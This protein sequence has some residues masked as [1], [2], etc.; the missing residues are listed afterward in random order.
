[1]RE[2]AAALSRPTQPD[3]FAGGG[4]MGNRMRSYDWAATNLGPPDGWPQSLKTTISIMLNSRYAMWMA[5]GPDL[6]FFCND[7]YEPTLGVKS[8]W[9]LGA[10][11]DQV[12]A[13]IWGDVGP[14]IQHVLANGGA[15]WD[16]SLLLLLE[17]R[18]F[19]EE[20][21]HTFSYSPLRTDTGEIG[22]M[23]CVVTE[24][25]ERVIGSRR[26]AMLRDLAAGLSTAKSEADVADSVRRILGEESR[27]L[28]F[29]LTYLFEADSAAARLVCATGLPAGHPAA[30]PTIDAGA[31]WPWPVAALRSSASPVRV[32]DLAVLGSLPSGGW[33]EPPRQALVRPIAQQGE[34]AA[35]GFLV[36]AINPFRPI[37]ASYEGFIALLAGQIAGSLASAR[38]HSDARRRAEALAELDRAKTAF[39]SNISHE[40]RTPLTLILGPLEALLAQQT[41]PLDASQRAQIETVHRNS[42]RLLKLVNSLLDFSRIEAGRIDA[43]FR[44]TDLSLVTADLASSFRSAMEAA[45]LEFLVDAPSLPQPVHVDRDMW[46]KIV[47]NLLSNAFKFTMQGRVHVRLRPSADARQAVLTVSDTGAGIPQAE[48]PRVFERFHR[49]QGAAGRTFEGSGIGLALVQDLVKLHGGTIG[50]DSELGSGTTFTVALPLGTA[51][52]PPERLGESG[53]AE[54]DGRRAVAYAEEARRWLPQSAGTDLSGAFDELV[55][56]G[57]GEQAEP[58]IPGGRVVL[59]DDNAD[60]RDFVRRL[61]VNRGYDV[62]AVADGQAALDAIRANR[63]DLVL[64]DVMM[65]QL[66]GFGLL[67][68]IRG[69]ADLR[70]IP[71][72]LL[73]ARAGEEARVGGV[74]AGADDYLTKPFSASELMARVD[75]NVALARARREAIQTLQSLNETL[76]VRVAERTRERDRVW[77]LSRALMLA[78][79]PDGTALATNPAWAETLGW[80]EA[81]LGGRSLLDLVHPDDKA[82]ATEALESIANGCRTFQVDCR[83]RGRDGL[84]RYVEWNAVAEEGIIYAV[85]RDV[86]D[87]KAA[88]ERLRQSQKMETIGQLT[89]GVAH[90]FNNLLTVIIGNIET[91]RRHIEHMDDA[92]ASRLRRAS[93]QAM[94]GADR[95]ATLTQRLLAFSRRQPLDPKPI[96]ANRLILGMSDLFNRTLGEH[97]AVETVVGVRLWLAHADPNQLENALL[98]LAVNARDAMPKGGKLTIET[99]NV[100]LDE[101]YTSSVSELSPGQY[102]QIAVSD[103]GTGMSKELSAQAFEPFFTTKD[104]GHGTGL[105]L[106]QVYGFVKQSGGHVKI[107]SELG[108]GTTVKIYLPRLVGAEVPQ[109]PDEQRQEAPPGDLGEMV[110]VVEDDDDVRAYSVEALRD[111]GYRVCEA[112]NGATALRVLK[113]EPRIRLLFTDVGLPGGMNGRQLADAARAL[114][115]RLLVLFTT[116][117]AR[118]AIVHGGRLDPGVHL[119]TKPFSYDELAAKVRDVLDSRMVPPRILVVEDEPLVSMMAAEALDEAGFAVEEAASAAEA[120]AKLRRESEVFDAV[121]LDMRL[122]D[123]TGDNLARE[124]RAMRADLP[125]VIASGYDRAPLQQLFA[126]DARIVVVAKPYLGDDLRVALRQLGVQTEPA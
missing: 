71:V 118:N 120:L 47:L 65:P 53:A 73:S 117:Y 82:T 105:G 7:A 31:T 80:D 21:Y 17:R 72:L 84:Y 89:G 110:L 123:G 121:I 28:P 14:R 5:W 100:Y 20:T 18:G 90:D 40:F 99:C 87:A 79:T 104:V 57:R 44:P 114:S 37:D 103:T 106:S 69:D 113:N 94:R 67:S 93:D 26:L 48:I 102:V 77:R 61:L 86:T 15:T 107:Y 54:T 51:H 8:A 63:P 9:A 1:M 66:D 98:N 68:A 19:P 3:L 109:E 115:P 49:V 10:A 58:D 55:S 125:I 126:D 13:E 25:T 33:N 42:M 43:T 96:D 81:A 78:A 36:T 76:E 38:A 119:I 112:P 50:V 62:E 116:G 111:L 60:M 27:D 12:W 30:P 122:P 52:L 32:S 16:E 39:F 29:T 24:E 35:A 97:V 59:A 4:V 23:L 34:D 124:L 70:N 11:S 95:A 92:L 46:E 75:A 41:P 45:G 85:G 6:T 22:G 83:T 91:I 108:E 88:A 64:S 101:R 56:A 74:N 2:A